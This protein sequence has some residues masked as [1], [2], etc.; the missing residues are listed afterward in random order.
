MVA[1][2]GEV[3]FNFYFPLMMAVSDDK[4]DD[5]VDSDRVRV[6]VRVRWH[7]LSDAFLLGDLIRITGRHCRQPIMF[8][9][10]P[11]LPPPSPVLSSSL[12]CLSQPSH[13]AISG[14]PSLPPFLVCGRHPSH[15]STLC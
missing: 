12:S 3:G 1:D 8:A 9:T 6:K 15:L 5:G 2:D 14:P 13:L 10:K 7:R 11:P 4:D